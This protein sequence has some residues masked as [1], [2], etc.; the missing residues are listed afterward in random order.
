MRR[1]IGLFLCAVAVVAASV[2]CGGDAFTLDGPDAMTGGDDG[3]VDGA[4]GMDASRGDGA[5]PE[6]S[7]PDAFD[8][9]KDSARPGEGGLDAGAPTDASM[10]DGESEGGTLDS[11]TG[12]GGK[13]GGGSQDA[14]TV[15]GGHQDAGGGGAGDAAGGGDSGACTIPCGTTCCVAGDTC[16]ST[17][18]L[19]LDGASLTSGVCQPSGQV[20][21]LSGGSAN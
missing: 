7:G 21:V 10:R 19:A 2:R 5:A 13:G 1:R 17:V 18:V 8:G 3:S 9:S 12:D 16:C 14:S 6:D 20:C 11:S 4:R 15:E